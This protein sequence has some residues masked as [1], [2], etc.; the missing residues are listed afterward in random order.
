LRIEFASD[1]AARGERAPFTL[2]HRTIEEHG[3]VEARVIARCGDATPVPVRVWPAGALDEFAGEIAAVES[4][5]C[6]IEATIGNHSAIGFIAIADRPALG[7]ETSLAKL[8]RASRELGGVVV[9]AGDESEIAR[10][11]DHS[12]ESSRVVSVYPMRASW[13]MVPFA[14]LLSLEWFLR[15]RVGLR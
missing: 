2:R 14:G 12:T 9:N 5:Q 8:E 1:I 10:A 3:A 7:I 11:L 15:R 4:G 6:E 13:W